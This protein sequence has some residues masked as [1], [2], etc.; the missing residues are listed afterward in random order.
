[1]SGKTIGIKEAKICKTEALTDTSG[2]VKQLQ[3]ATPLY[4]PVPKPTS[5]ETN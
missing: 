5:N 4:F 3:L 2:V 1:M